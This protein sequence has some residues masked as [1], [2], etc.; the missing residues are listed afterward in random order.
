M[1]LCF[2]YPE[3]NKTYLVT[4]WR[5][6]A[7]TDHDTDHD[8]RY[9]FIEELPKRLI[10]VLEGEK[11]RNELMEILQLKHNPTF[12]E[13][14]IEPAMVKG[15]IEMTVPDKPQSKK[16]RY[17]LTQAGALEK[18]KIANDYQPD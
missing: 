6:S 13:N 2:I 18:E 9:I 16:Q 14:Y 1:N 3:D 8:K 12:R 7:S 5:P 17:R 15:W 4:L 10:W 11:S